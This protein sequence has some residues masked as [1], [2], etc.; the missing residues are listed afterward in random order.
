CGVTVGFSLQVVNE[1]RD[2][3]E[4]GAC[5]ACCTVLGV[6]ELHKPVNV[7]CEHICNAGCAI[8]DER[9]R[10]CRDWSCD[11]KN[12]LIP[13]DEMRPDKVGVM[14]DLRIEGIDP[15]LCL[16]EVADGAAEQAGLD[17]VLAN[18]YLHAPCAVM[19]KDGSAY[20]YW[21]K[22]PLGRSPYQG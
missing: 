2:Q 12:G 19:K 21:T 15:L 13:G 18:V 4:C 7:E 14:F 8:Y 3:R 11:W 20:D 5:K 9:P 16:W 17:Q 1:R 10:T 22:S 6:T